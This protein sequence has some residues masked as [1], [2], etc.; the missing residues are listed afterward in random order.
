MSL[1]PTILILALGPVAQAEDPMQNLPAQAQALLATSAETE[2]HL[3]S[4]YM[5]KLID[6]QNKLLAQLDK[7]CK[8]LARDGN[9]DGALAVKKRMAAISDSIHD[10][11]NTLVFAHL[12]AD[13][14]E[15]FLTSTSFTFHYP[16]GSRTLRFGSHGSFSEGANENENT[17]RLN[18][19]K[20]ELVNA[21]HQVFSRWNCDPATGDWTNEKF[22]DVICTQELTLV[23]AKPDDP[24]N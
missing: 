4:D 22:G 17:W 10:E 6:E 9:L 5:Q 21:N 12:D 11:K 7:L 20:L 23:A 14:I 15:K 3:Q 2:A 8:S 19:Q 1:L 24:K 16:G 18:G 13:D